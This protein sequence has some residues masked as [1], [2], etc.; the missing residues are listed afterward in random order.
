M[1]RKKRP[2]GILTGFVLKAGSLG[3]LFIT[4]Q[5]LSGTILL[6]EESAPQAVIA[7]SA[8]ENLLTLNFVQTDIRE[9][10]SALAIQQEKNIVMAKDVSGEVSVHLYQVP[11]DRALDLICQA[12]GFRF[13]KQGNIYFVFKPKKSPKP[14]TA[15]VEMRIFKFQYADMDKIQE[16]LTAIPN[17]RMIK[18]HEPSKTV[19][20][21]DIP[22]NIAKVETLIRFLDARPKQV[23]IEATI[24]SALLTEDMELGVDWNLAA[25]VGISGVAGL[26]DPGITAGSLAETTGFAA[27]GG[28][29][30]KL[31][32][33]TGDVREF[34]TALETITDITVLATP[35]IMTVN[36][37]KGSLLI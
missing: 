23:L 37:K 27:T 11:F 9:I 10:L 17:I 36:K 2:S 6:G 33:T 24:L 19:V 21:E 1:N 13:R 29:G 26:K 5:L 18:I 22:E 3:V 7:P 35:K 8:G 20:V 34:V 4:I 30:L 15:R 14:P 12:G 32:I 31:G 25:G 28:P 16:V